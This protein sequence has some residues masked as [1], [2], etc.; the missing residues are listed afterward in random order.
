MFFSLLVIDKYSEHCVLYLS[1]L[2]EVAKQN[3]IFFFFFFTFTYCEL[4]SVLWAVH[5]A[6]PHWCRE[7]WDLISLA[8]RT[9]IRD[10]SIMCRS[11]KLYP[12]WKM[13]FVADDSCATPGFPSLAYGWWGSKS[14]LGPGGWIWNISVCLIEWSMEWIWIFWECERKLAFSSSLDHIWTN[15]LFSWTGT[16]K[17]G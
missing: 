13:W 15:C 4:N 5:H 16:K 10:F 9:L 2:R 12:C 1:F 11:A 7:E 17:T 14:L 3:V 8:L 6:G